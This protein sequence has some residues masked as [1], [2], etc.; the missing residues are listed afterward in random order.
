MNKDKI[1]LSLGGSIIVPDEVDV[2][3]IKK[4][5][6]LVLK[7]K[8]KYQFF[9]ITGGGKICRRYQ[10]AAGKV[11]K[12][13]NDQL[14]WIGIHAS[15]FNA[16]LMYNIFK[17]YSYPEIVTDPNFSKKV[18]DDFIW[19]A[20]WKP[21]W[22]TDYDAVMIA[23]KQGVKRVVNLSNIAY[24]YDKDPRKFKDAKKLKEVSWKEFRKI[25]GSKWTPGM[26]AP[27][28]PIA[29]KLAEK[30]GIEVIIAKGTD[31]KNLQNI[32]EGKSF[33]GTIIK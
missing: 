24:A 7:K 28:D 33:K 16:Q 21:G 17:K 31:L 32:L 26:S 15:R 29:S 12:L 19:G 18:K 30:H 14:D 8:N 9:I 3:F 4:F 1:V 23:V 2:K 13:N 27:F 25:V 5:K 20:G 10:E 6:D 22:S 11:T